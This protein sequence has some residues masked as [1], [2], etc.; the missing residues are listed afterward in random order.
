MLG[1]PA[2][3]ATPQAE[4]DTVAVPAILHALPPHLGWGNGRSAA[5]LR[6]QSG[7]GTRPGGCA[8]EDEQG[9]KDALRIDIKVAHEPPKAKTTVKAYPSILNALLKQEQAAA[10]RVW[11]LCRHLDS[12]GR[13]WIDVTD[14]RQ[15]LTKRK[16]EGGRRKAEISSF[17]LHPSSF[18]IFGWRRL[19]QI[20]GQGKGVFLESEM[21]TDGSGF[22]GQRVWRPIWMLSGC[23][24]GR[25]NSQCLS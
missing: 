4:V 14:L 15:A 3:G 19:R 12:D 2:Q 1:R 6:A 18:P 24:I 21:N 25:Y 11:L 13:G 16:A 22:L 20:L 9:E 17:I 5:V 10:G 23:K 8:V 7:S